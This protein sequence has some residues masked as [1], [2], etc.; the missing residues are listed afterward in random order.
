M[1]RTQTKTTM[2][3]RDD[4]R[5]GD[6]LGSHYHKEAEKT[7]QNVLL[8]LVNADTG[9]GACAC[10]KKQKG[11]EGG[12][13]VVHGWELGG[14]HREGGG[15]GLRGIVVGDNRGTLRRRP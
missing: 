9:G 7:V 10:R 12:V 13:V 3:N 15:G 5:T 14:I 8:P 2:I 11:E 1:G 6:R 4:R